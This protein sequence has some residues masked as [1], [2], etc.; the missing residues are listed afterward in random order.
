MRLSETGTIAH[1]FLEGCG[2]G[3]GRRGV[4]PLRQLAHTLLLGGCLWPSAKR[5]GCTGGGFSSALSPA[6]SFCSAGGF[7]RGGGHLPVTEGLLLSAWRHLFIWNEDLQKATSLVCSPQVHCGLLAFWC[8]QESCSLASPGPS[9]QGK[10]GPVFS[11]DDK[12]HF[13][14]M[15]PWRTGSVGRGLD[16]CSVQ[17]RFMYCGRPSIECD[18]SRVHAMAEGQLPSSWSQPWPGP[19]SACPSES[20]AYVNSISMNV[21]VYPGY[22]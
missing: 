11:S 21:Q 16:P 6:S 22:P 19:C 17:R 9:S 18:W 8:R 4:P 14:T 12:G 15:I 7:L 10:A 2:A 20:S 3:S 5:Q 13:A 1:L